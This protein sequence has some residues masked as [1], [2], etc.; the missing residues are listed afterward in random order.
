LMQSLA[1]IAARLTSQVLGTS[2]KS[3]EAPIKD[4]EP[5]QDQEIWGEV[6]QLWERFMSSNA[7]LETDT[8]SMGTPLPGAAASPIMR[9]VVER[10][11][12]HVEDVLE[13]SPTDFTF[14]GIW[15]DSAKCLGGRPLRPLF[16]RLASPPDRDWR[17]RLAA[18]TQQGI[19]AEARERKDWQAMK[20]FL[21]PMLLPAIGP[22]RAGLGFNMPTS[23]AVQGLLEAYLRLGETASAD[24]LVN[25]MALINKD[26]A[27]YGWAAAVAKRL[28]LKSLESQWARSA[29]EPKDP[30]DSR[31]TRYPRTQ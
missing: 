6:A 21:E 22:E 17:M 29:P 28:D 3:E 7:W 24:S 8:R 11:L 20:T 26:G 5:E 18:V 13:R 9:G 15:L 27:V 10:R 16:A 23:E 31:P 19:V 14:W 12:T 4:L 1:R 30:K 2:P 25:G